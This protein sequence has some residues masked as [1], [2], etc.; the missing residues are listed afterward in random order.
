M[1]ETLVEQIES[2]G[3]QVTAL[4]D[5]RYQVAGL[6]NGRP[7]EI[8]DSIALSWWWLGA[9]AGLSLLSPRIDYHVS[10]RRR[11]TC[12]RRGAGGVGCC[13]GW[14][15]RHDALLDSGA[16]AASGWTASCAICSGAAG[17]PRRDRCR[18]ASAGFPIH[19]PYPDGT[20]VAEVAALT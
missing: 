3:L 1:N 7:V 9:A 2:C 15:W 19:P 8:P 10:G 17:G 11:G 13:G 5:G 18:S 20:P 14:G 6:V 4:P 16:W 12:C